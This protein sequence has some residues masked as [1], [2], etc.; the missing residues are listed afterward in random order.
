MTRPADPPRVPAPDAAEQD[1]VQPRPRGSDF[2]IVGVG[3]SAGGLDAFRQ[4][5]GALP[6][7]T[8]MAFVLVQHLDPSHE[9]ILA[10]LLAKG[11]RMPVSEVRGDTLVE[12][13][14]VYVTPGR[15]DV[16]LEGD[17][18]KLVPRITSGADTCPSTPSCARWPRPGAT[19]RSA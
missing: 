17:A 5:L 3:A 9:S 19:R 14:H 15:N 13:D 16:A 10:E 12:P 1:E 18:L 7:D 6:T 8:G 11:S 2:P 4:L